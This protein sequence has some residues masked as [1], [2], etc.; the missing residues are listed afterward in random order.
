M[1]DVILTLIV[2]CP[3]V[4]LAGLID[5]VAGGGGL[6]SLPAYM[7]AGLPPH[8]ATGTNKCSSTFGTL[9]STLRFMKNKKICYYSAITSAA[10]ALIGSYL[11]ARLNMIVDE[12]YLKYMLL[13]ALPIIALFL[14]FKKDFG[15]ESHMNERKPVQVVILSILSGL[16]IGAYDGFFGPG[17]GTFL[18]LI[19]TGIIGFDLLI[20]SGNA[21]IVNLASNV[22]A[23]IT[24]ALG[25]KILWSIGIPA[26]LFGILGNWVGSGLALKGGKKI[27]K[28]MFFV[29]LGLLMCKIIYDF[30]F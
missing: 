30:I 15:E 3:L 16:L 27:I 24:F 23:F 18:I 14:I 20:A 26:A 9:F 5:A 21:K 6:I 13:I 22:A 4:F 12:K 8:L 7:A 1:N 10:M 11:G 2:V 19:Y 17:T 25:G 28:P 29:T